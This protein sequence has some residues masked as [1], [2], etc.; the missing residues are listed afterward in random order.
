MSTELLRRYIDILEESQQLDEGMLS[1]I[2]PTLKKFAMQALNLPQL[3]PYLKQAKGMFPEIKQA[4]ESSKSGQEFTSKLQKL[5][6]TQAQV[7]EDFADKFVIGL[8][9]F[10]ASIGTL[11]GWTLKILPSSA[12][13]ASD[14]DFEN[15]MTVFE[16]LSNLDKAKGAQIVWAGITLAVILGGIYIAVS[17]YM[18]MRKQKEYEKRDRAAEIK[19]LI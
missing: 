19:N 17:K 6:G 13:Y 16:I 14:A 3:A 12:Q 10:L 11:A 8:G 9:V 4:L 1:S 2:L 15:M 7:N 18:E 5:A